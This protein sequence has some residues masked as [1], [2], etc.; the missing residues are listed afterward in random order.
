MKHVLIASL[1]VA[2]L[3]ACSSVKLDTAPVEDKS[4]TLVGKSDSGFNHNQLPVPV[5]PFKP[6]L[7][8]PNSG[9][10]PSNNDF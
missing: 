2:F 1:L 7:D 8:E 4:G 3:T 5:S 9:K 10:I 6:K